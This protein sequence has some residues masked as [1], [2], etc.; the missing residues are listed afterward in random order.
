VIGKT[1]F[2]FRAREGFKSRK[3]VGVRGSFYSKKRDECLSA[4][5]IALPAVLANL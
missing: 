3:M 2:V 1:R 5:D 4:I